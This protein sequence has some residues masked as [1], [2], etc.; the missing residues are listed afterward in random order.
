MLRRA[1]LDL[2]DFP[3]VEMVLRACSTMVM[4]RPLLVLVLAALCLERL[5]RLAM[6]LL[7]L[8]LEG[9]VLEFDCLPAGLV[10]P[11]LK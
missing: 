7:H 10:M 9:G 8:V 2:C 6:G 11:E 1:A 5:F 3:G 4:P